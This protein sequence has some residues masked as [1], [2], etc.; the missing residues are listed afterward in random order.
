M[1]WGGPAILPW[2]YAK[3]KW[4]LYGNTLKKLPPY[5]KKYF[6]PLIFPPPPVIIN[7]RYLIEGN[8]QWWGLFSIDFNTK[9]TW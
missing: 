7:E 1:A 4:P 9:G 3:K 8:M 2:E 5:T 6:P